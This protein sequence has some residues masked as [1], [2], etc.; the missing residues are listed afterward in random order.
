MSLVSSIVHQLL[1]DQRTA[2]VVKYIEDK[3]FDLMTI[4]ESL[5]W[6]SLST[7]IQRARGI[8]F[9]LVIDAFDEME[10]EN[11]QNHHDV[12]NR[13]VNLFSDDLSGHLRIF[14]TDR[15]PPP[16]KFSMIIKPELIDMVNPEM[17]KGVKD[18][19][20]IQVRS[21]LEEKGISLQRGEEIEKLFQISMGNFLQAT[22]CWRK[23]D[24]DMRTWSQDEVNRGLDSL[25]IM[26]P[27]LNSFYCEIL[28]SIP[29]A[30]RSR[31]RKAFSI[32]LVACEP[33]TDRQLAYL[34]ALPESSNAPGQ[35]SQV[36][37]SMHDFLDFLKKYC[38]H[39]VTKDDSSLVSFTHQS[40]K[41]LL[42][43]TKNDEEKSSIL[44]QFRMSAAEAHS[45]LLDLCLK[46][47]IFEDRS[48]YE[49]ESQFEPLL[50][51]CAEVIGETQVTKDVGKV[52]SMGIYRIG[53]TPCLLYVIRHWD[54][55]YR[56]ASTDS[57]TDV[58]VVSFLQSPSAYYYNR[59]WQIMQD[60]SPIVTRHL[61]VT[62]NTWPLYHL[63][64]RDDFPALVRL[65]IERGED[66]SMIDEKAIISPLSW[67]IMCE[68]RSSFKAILS[69][70]LVTP[71]LAEQNGWKPIHHAVNSGDPFFIRE[72]V[73]TPNIN[74]NVRGGPFRRSPLVH[75]IAEKKFEAA[76]ILLEAPG[77]EL[78]AEDAEGNT[79]YKIALDTRGSENFMRI[80]LQML[81]AKSVISGH[82]P[83][84]SALNIAGARGWTW[85]EE[86]II[87]EKPQFVIEKDESGFNILGWYAFYGRRKKLLWFLNRIPPGLP[88]RRDR[89]RPLQSRQYLR[90]PGLARYH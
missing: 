50:G 59:F 56:K 29:V 72:L 39:I 82:H 73:N 44:L 3:A 6:D 67:S 38:G 32:I 86:R 28:K 1:C 89:L 66:I 87:Q 77:I 84:L 23:F 35:V 36:S 14:V 63:I 58:N 12:V 25:H 8:V 88:N 80:L 49:W 43:S 21:R 78:E 45:L 48:R 20:R 10:K 40:V 53:K 41:D 27:G 61:H 64:L 42:S 13:L 30:W 81:D 18:F 2:F 4:P 5:L 24:H 34:T 22:L 46:V 90:S 19:L 11:I 31:A 9:Q 85:V 52:L 68:R 65:L 17:R 70:K 33:L 71:N 7:I 74:I 57:G 76:N 47:F 75:S 16:Y 83:S 54:S 62:E 37:Y 69:S 51:V 15:Q 79:P 60:F 26:S 55:H